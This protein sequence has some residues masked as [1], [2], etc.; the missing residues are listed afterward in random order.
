MGFPGNPGVQGEI[1]AHLLIS[2]KWGKP[3]TF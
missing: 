2:N 3:V 1:V